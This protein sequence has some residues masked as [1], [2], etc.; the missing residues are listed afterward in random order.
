MSKA[1]WLMLIWNLRST[2]PQTIYFQLQQIYYVVGKS[3]FEVE[4]KVFAYFTE[5][6]L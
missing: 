5:G 1:T 4:K 3:H 2:W 6:V